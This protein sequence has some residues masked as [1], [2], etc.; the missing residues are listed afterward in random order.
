[1]IIQPTYFSVGHKK[2]KIMLDDL[3]HFVE[4]W[5]ANNSKNI[6]VKYAG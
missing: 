5:A 2:L 3:E 6:L 4:R 1:M